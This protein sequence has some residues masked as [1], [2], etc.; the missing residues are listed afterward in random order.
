MEIY[1]TDGTIAAS[2]W[3]AR[4]PLVMWRDDPRLGLR[5]WIE[6]EADVRPLD[7]ASGVDH[8]VECIL[9]GKQ[10][11]PSGEHARHVVEI[12]NKAIEAARTGRT[13][14]LKTIF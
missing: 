1:G 5:G 13:Q 14:E 9:D 7:L 3:E 10:I 2:V 12:M 8:M 11:I 4:Q 6:V